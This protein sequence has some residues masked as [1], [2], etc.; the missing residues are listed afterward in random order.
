[1]VYDVMSSTYSIT[2]INGIRISNSD[3]RAHIQINDITI[4]KN[5]TIM[6]ESRD[7]ESNLIS[8]NY[9]GCIKK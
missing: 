2:F 8:V 5:F 7:S 6:Q 4:N 1:M 9:I 3:T